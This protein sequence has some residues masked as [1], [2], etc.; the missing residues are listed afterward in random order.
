VRLDC[1]GNFSEK[2]AGLRC[3]HVRGENIP[4]VK[5]EDGIDMGTRLGEIYGEKNGD[6]NSKTTTKRDAIFVLV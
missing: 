5:A 4:T 2:R 1:F 6:K 3:R